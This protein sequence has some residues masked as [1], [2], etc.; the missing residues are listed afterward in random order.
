MVEKTWQVMGSKG[1][2]VV[3]LRHNPFT[4]WL[5]VQVDGNETYR[6]TWKLANPGLVTT[7]RVDR[8]LLPLKVE[9][10]E[11]AFSYS[12]ECNGRALAP[13]EWPLPP[14][15]LHLP[16]A[17]ENIIRSGVSTAILIIMAILSLI[18]YSDV[19]ALIGL[20][21]FGIPSLG[22]CL[23]LGNLLV[24]RLELDS[25]GITQQGLLSRKVISWKDVST[26]L[27][28][29]DGQG[30]V[31]GNRRVIHLRSGVFTDLRSLVWWIEFMAGKRAVKTPKFSERWLYRHSSIALLL[32]SGPLLPAYIWLDR[33][34]V[35]AGI[36]L[37]LL[38]GGIWAC[39]VGKP[40]PG[41][42]PFIK[43]L[44]ASVLIFAFLV[45]RVD[46][47]F[48]PLL[49]LGGGWGL[50]LSASLARDGLMQLMNEQGL[51]I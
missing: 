4:G 17:R 9:G 39:G 3:G 27:V 37:G 15:P 20:L 12:L 2:H 13:R 50:M 7:I 21:V 23:W 19:A 38:T 40:R 18:L 10:R 30:R 8:F 48:L 43:Q 33:T 46:L 29:R 51:Y 1:E 49:I 28:D 24:T 31:E 42:I 45:P 5:T 41:S 35:V 11:G 44:L 32:L 26:I 25:L 14:G 6:R 16:A 36:M 47:V 34:P 22:C